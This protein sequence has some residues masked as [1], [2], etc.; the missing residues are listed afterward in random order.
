MKKGG[1][2]IYISANSPGEISG[3]LK[4]VVRM[5]KK[6]LPEYAISVILL[7]CV[8]ASGRE[9]AVIGT[10]PEVDEVVPSWE[11]FSL[12]R[13]RRDRSETEL[14]HLGGD[15][16]FTALLAR[17]WKTSAWGY[18]WGRKGID[19]YYRG[20][21]VKA[22]RDME[23]LERRGI[24]R[25]K[26]HVVGDLIKDSVTDGCTELPGKTGREQIETICFMPGSRL[27]EVRSLL[28]FYLKLASLIK[29]EFGD[30]KFKALIS[31]YISWDEFVSEKE[32]QPLKE[33]GGAAGE[34]DGTRKLFSCDG[35]EIRL[36]NEN[37]IQEMADSD[38]L[39]TIPGTKT[40]EAGCL[41]KPMAVLLP[42]NKPEDI[43]F[44]GVIGLLDWLPWLGP[45]IKGPILMK[46]AETFGWVAQPNILANREVVPEI[47]GILDADDV[48][49]RIL[50]I[51]RDKERLATMR[52]DL[53]E[54]YGPF[55]GAASRMIRIF[56]RAVNPGFDLASPYFS[57]IICTRN[58]C[59]L[60]RRTIETL[61]TQD[62]PSGGYEVI[63][64]DDGS[65]DGTEEMIRSLTTRC[66]L[67]YFKRSWSG[68]A[69]TRNYGIG[70][71]AGEVII[72]V[73][74]DI[75]APADFVLEHARF[76]RM[77]P[78]TIVRGPIINVEKYEFPRDHRAGIAD[79][80]QAFFCTCNVSVGRR[81]LIE[82]G[83]FDETFLEYGYEDNEVGWRLRQ[84]GLKVRFNMKAIVYHYKPRKKEE[85]LDGLIRTA[86][87]L[88]RSAVLYF[89]KHPHWKVR[90]AT[91][92]YPFYFLKQWFIANA[93][94][95]DLCLKKWKERVRGGLDGLLPLE[96]KI[97]SYY[98]AESLR[99]E[100]KKRAA[101]RRE[102]VQS[103]G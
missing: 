47:K 102:S 19:R 27:K 89:T 5:I 99:E 55:D 84:K 16:N 83:G 17:S 40:G 98:Y 101:M 53:G 66:T 69:A 52:K 29:A 38:F 81:D 15:I 37:H 57:I 91:G 31:P 33:L 56:A 6:L 11:Y 65:E 21:F 44:I 85:D 12:L 71:A 97:F 28:P 54:I 4:P 7:P 92:I 64:V 42:L 73:D 14:L 18:Q 80:S 59:E 60:L 32:M 45:R 1:K 79:F 35:A 96:K 9:K 68:R 8:F 51:L 46:M 23:E 70:Q 82:V 93:F 36:V 41:V 48:S 95:K 3:W 61:D 76:H 20:Y 63:V 94:I 67:R 74:D 77:F 88:A 72:F 26:I 78:R 30:M 24:S 13:D 25:S 103:G 100:L 34:I 2:R 62:Y 43:P 90:L 49:R 86:R 39:V 50:E 22:S 75:L 58:R 87:E 10:I